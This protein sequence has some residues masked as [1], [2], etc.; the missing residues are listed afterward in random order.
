MGCITSLTA[1]PRKITTVTFS[2]QDTTNTTDKSACQKLP[3]LKNPTSLLVGRA[4]VDHT[5][6]TVPN[7]ISYQLQAET[8]FR[9][10]TL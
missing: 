6:P 8:N 9:I 4:T 3:L 1:T 2:R 10:R 5:P 7:K